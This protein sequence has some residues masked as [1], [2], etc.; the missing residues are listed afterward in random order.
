ML[1]HA[2]RLPAPQSGALPAAFGE[3]PEADPDRFLV[4]LAALSLLDEVAAQ[5]PVLGVIDD[6][7]WLDDASAAA[8]AFVAR[9]LRA[10]RVAML[11]AAGAT[12]AGPDAAAAAGGRR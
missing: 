2:A 4:F 1:D 8:L 3:V 11:F 9:R 12:G 10:E 7:H 6:A 5:G